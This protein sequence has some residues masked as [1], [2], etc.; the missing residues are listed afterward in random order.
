MEQANSQ[1]CYK[2]NQEYYFCETRRL[3][4]KQKIAEDTVRANERQRYVQR[5]R[6][7]GNNDNNAACDL[8]NTWATITTWPGACHGTPAG[9]FMLPLMVM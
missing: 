1:F 6:R 4:N 8:H 2:V 7:V 3:L 5:R 9:T